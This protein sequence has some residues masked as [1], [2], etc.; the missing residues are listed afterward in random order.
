ME[1]EQ[2]RQ[3]LYESIANALGASHPQ[4]GG[5]LRFAESNSAT[6]HARN[7]SGRRTPN[8]APLFA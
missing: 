5:L 8:K 4:I 1:C 2:P 3:R 6:F 7:R